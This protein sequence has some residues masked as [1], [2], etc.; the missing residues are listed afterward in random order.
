MEKQQL[1]LPCMPVKGRIEKMVCY[2]EK[3]NLFLFQPLM[4]LVLCIKSCKA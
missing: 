3:L 1:I 2:R 4:Y